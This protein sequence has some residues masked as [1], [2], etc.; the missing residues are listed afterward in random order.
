MD[1]ELEA[2]ADRLVAARRA[3]EMLPDLPEHE[4]PR[5]LAEAYRQQ[6][7]FAERWDD[8][9]AGWKVGATSAEVQRLFGI[10]EPVLGPVFRRD[11]HR[12]P[13]RLP[14]AGFQHRLLE[15]EFALR[16]GADLPAQP[17]PRSR[18][19]V[20]AAVDAVLPAMEVISPRFDRLTTDRMPQLVADCVANGAAVLGEPCPDW[21]SLDLPATA[22][23]LAIEGR[24]VREGTGA[25]VMGD[26]LAVFQWLVNA[27]GA[28]GIGLVAGQVVLTG[29]TTGLHAPEPGQLAR[30]EFG[31]LGAVE[32]VFA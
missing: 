8:G 4:R 22:V 29:T 6:R 15:S 3:V 12:S 21:R 26:P 23:R 7:L 5:S 14:A 25:L 2:G 19:A 18:D 10:R 17:E 31:A 30:A 1:P 11:L 9:I 16:L 20:L 27:L 24:L 13:A 32:L 28:R